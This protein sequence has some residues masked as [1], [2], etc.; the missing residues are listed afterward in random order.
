MDGLFLQ[1]VEAIGESP[2]VGSGGEIWELL[3]SEKEHVSEEILAEDAQVSCEMTPA[4]E[5]EPSEESTRTIS[6]HNRQ[7]LEER[8]R[9]INDAQDRLVDGGYGICLEC[10]TRIEPKRLVADPAASL[11][12]SCQELSEAEAIFRTL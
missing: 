2:F 5:F 1:S 12:I 4:N 8:L 6:W 11:C 10:G 3:Q 9:A 7:K